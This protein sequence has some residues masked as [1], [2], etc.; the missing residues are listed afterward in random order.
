MCGVL[1]FGGSSAAM[2]MDGAGPMQPISGPDAAGA[3]VFADGGAAGMAGSQGCESVCVLDGDQ[4]CSSAVALTA[5]SL[6]GL[7]LALR[8]STFLHAARRLQSSGALRRAWE[9]TPPWTVLSPTRL[10]VMRV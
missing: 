8:R 7:L 9:G 2:D 4:G 1:V 6:F 5:V 10:C 3:A